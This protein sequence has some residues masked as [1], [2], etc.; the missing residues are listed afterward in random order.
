MMI[1]LNVKAVV[2]SERVTVDDTVGHDSLFDDRHQGLRFGIFNDLGVDLPSALQDA[3]NGNLARSSSPTLSF[4]SAAKV[5]LIDLY[6]TVERP[7][8]LLMGGNGFPASL[9]EENS[10]VAIHAGH[11]SGCSSCRSCNEQFHKLIDLALGEFAP[12]EMHGWQCKRGNLLG[13]PQKEFE[14]K[15]KDL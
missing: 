1:S 4:A 8:T 10:S 2:T 3:E 11:L 15:K 12:L 9:E 6:F 7:L 13:Q 14:E 5:T